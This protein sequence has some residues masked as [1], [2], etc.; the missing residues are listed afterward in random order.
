MQIT[1]QCSEIGPERFEICIESK[2]RKLCI[3]DSTLCPNK[4]VHLLLYEYLSQKSGDLNY[5][6]YA[7]SWRNF[8]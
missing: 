2:K 3:E 1:I 6:L 7:E 4:N 5:S 8:T